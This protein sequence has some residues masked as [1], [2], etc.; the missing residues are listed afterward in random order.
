MPALQNTKGRMVGYK[1][2]K[3]M[4]ISLPMRTHLQIRQPSI[5]SYHNDNRNINRT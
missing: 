3:H 1:T 4:V 2:A 5:W